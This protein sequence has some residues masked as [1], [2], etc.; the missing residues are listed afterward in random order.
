VHEAPDHGDVSLTRKIIAGLLVAAAIVIPL[1]INT[2]ASENHRLFGFPFFFW[3]QL[4]WVLIASILTYSAY[5]L[6]EHGRGGGK[7]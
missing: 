6:I 7:K 1:V 3:Y 2:Y 4:M 5:L